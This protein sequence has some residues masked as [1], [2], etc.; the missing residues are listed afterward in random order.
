MQESNSG[1]DL[2]D[3]GKEGLCQ[4]G[5]Q[6]DRNKAQKAGFSKFHFQFNQFSTRE[7]KRIILHF[8]WILPPSAGGL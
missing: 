3:S 6:E 1:L 5:E 7:K 8:S 4:R 2:G